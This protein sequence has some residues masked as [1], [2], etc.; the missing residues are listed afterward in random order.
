MTNV[1]GLMIV[2]KQAEFEEALEVMKTRI[3]TILNSNQ[4]SLYLFGSGV[5][6]DF[7]QG[8]SDI[9]F[10]CLTQ[11]PINEE[12][13]KQL[14][15]L[16]SELSHEY[17]DG[18]RDGNGNGNIN[19]TYFRSFE[20]AF[21]SLE[22][23]ISKEPDKV[24]Y[25]GTSGQRITTQ[26]SFDPFSMTILLE[27]GRLLYGTDVRNLLSFPT[28]EALRSAIV[29]HYQ[30]I[31]KYAIKTDSSLYSAGWL[32]DIARCLYTLQTGK[33]I[34]KTKAGEWAL[35]Q[36]LVPDREIMG[37]ALAIRKEPLL[38]KNDMAVLTWLES[39]GDPIQAF[40]DVLQNQLEN[41]EGENLYEYGCF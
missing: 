40:A 19:C 8:W 27:H 7:K 24:V 32:L 2:T 10:V 1:K 41:N 21:L 31:R 6:D 16:R 11:V 26:Y 13:A 36:N 12:Q 33:V 23:F 3:V 22:A 38:F 25:W 15:N 18:D 29:D 37:K 9:D 20:G 17:A 14:L 34:A 39:L 30:A 5:L 35:D 28:P 4:P